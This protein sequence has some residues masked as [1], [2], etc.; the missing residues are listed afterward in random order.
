L[1]ALDPLRE[2]GCRQLMLLLALSGQRSVALSQYEKCR[3]TLLNQLGVEP[4]Q[5][6]VDLYER[7]K[8]GQVGRGTGELRLWPEHHV[9]V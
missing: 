4:T 7:I 8:V 5:E 1:L 9:P 3:D 6:T 2:D